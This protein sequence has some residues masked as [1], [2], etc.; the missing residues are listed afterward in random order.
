MLPA[1]GYCFCWMS[2]P[3]EINDGT[4]PIRME[5]ETILDTQEVYIIS[6]FIKN[7]Q[8]PLCGGGAGRCSQG[9]QTR[10]PEHGVTDWK[11]VGGN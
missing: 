6:Q 8:R 2:T 5:Q 7:F 11:V 1:V 3:R 10:R 9:A 4:L